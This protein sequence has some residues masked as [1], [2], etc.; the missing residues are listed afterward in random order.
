MKWLH[1]DTNRIL[2]GLKRRSSLYWNR[3][4]AIGVLESIRNPY[5]MRGGASVLVELRLRDGY[6]ICCRI[7][8]TDADVF[9]DTFVSQYHLPPHGF[10]PRTI[11]DLGS[12][13][14]TTIVHYAKL[15][16]EARILGI[17]LDEDNF[18]LCQR[19]IAA[20]GHRCAVLRGA[21][22]FEEAEVAY[23]GAQAWGLRVQANGAWKARAHSIPQLLV[24]RI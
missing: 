22:W 23:G 16:P 3:Y 10:R 21:A 20:L 6:P 1:Y 11:L 8:T 19:N 15:Y 5:R 24:A 7:G 14:G 18:C 13:I 17:E 2:R 9:Y 4:R 12:N